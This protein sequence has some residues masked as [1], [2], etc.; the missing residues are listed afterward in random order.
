[1]TAA[2]T[3]CRGMRVMYRERGRIPLGDWGKLVAVETV[4]RCENDDTRQGLGE[5]GDDRSAS[6]LL[7]L[8][9]IVVGFRG[10]DV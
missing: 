2:M 10:R 3:D 4:G 9:E 1:M 7:T 8:I 5:S 6:L